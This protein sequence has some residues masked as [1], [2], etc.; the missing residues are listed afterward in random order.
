MIW[1]DKS[2]TLLHTGKDNSLQHLKLLMCFNDQKCLLNKYIKYTFLSLPVCDCRLLK[3]RAITVHLSENMADNKS[4]FLLLLHGFQKAS[5]AWHLIHHRTE[6]QMWN[7]GAIWCRE[8]KSWWRQAQYGSADGALQSCGPEFFL[9][10]KPHSTLTD[11]YVCWA[12]GNR[13]DQ[14]SWAFVERKWISFSKGYARILYAVKRNQYTESES[15]WANQLIMIA[16][17]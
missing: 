3:K 4:L 15:I 2:T 17:T 8:K 14:L 9:Y 7:D 16:C 13:N 12:W 5:C 11:Q 6:K 10:A 1:E